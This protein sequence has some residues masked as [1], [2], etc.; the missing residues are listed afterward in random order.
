MQSSSQNPT[1]RSTWE[2]YFLYIFGGITI[3]HLACFGAFWT[4]VHTIDWVV[5]FLLYFIR[6]FAITGGYHRYFSHRT[7]KTSR[8]FQFI[9]AFV[10]QTSSQKGALWWAAHHREHHRESDTLNDVH[11]PVRKG[12]LYSHIG[13][14]YRLQNDYT[15]YE[16]ISDFSKYPELVFL[17][18]NWLIPPV[19]LGVFIGLWL[20][21]SGLIVGFCLSTVLLWHGTFTINSLSHIYGYQDYYTGDH[22]KNNWLLSIITLGEGWHNNHHFY[23]SSTRQGFKWW[24]VDI[25]YYILKLISWIGLVWDLR[26]PPAEVLA[27]AG[28]HIRLA[29]ASMLEP[30]TNSA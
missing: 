15:P 21:W 20:G 12:F 30:K 8:W 6:M 5:C 24:Q 16:K 4:G 26:E 22:S 9:L 28:I 25:T 19:T 3:L 17:N 11:S 18:K 2:T 13:W 1:E 23:Q 29:Q 10:A 14:L 7:Y 27:A